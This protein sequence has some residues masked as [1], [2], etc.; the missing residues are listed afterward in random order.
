MAKCVYCG[1]ETEL[2][3]GGVPIC[4][5]CSEQRGAKHKPPNS[6]QIRAALVGQIARATA[7]VSSANHKFSEAMGQSGLPHPDGA[8]LIKNT[9]NEL[10]VAR[11]EMLKAHTRLNDYNRAGRSELSG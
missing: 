7:W 9:S 5:K 11:E 1:S 6:D 2:Y 10:A 3:D 4:L 8:R